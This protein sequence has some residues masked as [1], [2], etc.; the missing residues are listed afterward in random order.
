M[1]RSCPACRGEVGPALDAVVDPHSGERFRI[2]RCRACGHGLTGP[3]PGDLAPYYPGDYYGGRHGLTARL[4][5][6]RRIRWLSRSRPEPGRVLDVGAGD[7]SFLLAAKRAGWEVCG[8]ERNPQPLRERGIPVF[9]SLAEA[10]G[11]GSFDTVTLWHSLEHFVDPGRTLAEARAALAPDGR[12]L[13]AVPRASSLQARIFGRNWMHLDVPRHLHHFTDRSL[14]ALLGAC[15][16]RVESRWRCEFEYDLMGWVQGIGNAL[17]PTR[18]LFFQMAAGKRPA[19]APAWERGAALFAGAVS[20]AAC[21]PVTILERLA[22]RGG[23]LAVLAA[24]G[25]DL[26]GAGDRKCR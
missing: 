26:P 4:C 1:N 15:G 2:D 25:P 5:F 16:F 6:R 3:V 23:T 13:V 12:L 18:N 20:A 19:F 22:N 10:G 17:L 24:P 9:E 21:L 8:I 14:D 7:G 11:A